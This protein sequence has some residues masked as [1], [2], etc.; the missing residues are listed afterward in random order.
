MSRYH[1]IFFRRIESEE[2][3]IYDTLGQTIFGSKRRQR[4][5]FFLYERPQAKISYIKRWYVAVTHAKF[6]ASFL[7]SRRLRKRTGGLSMIRSNCH[8]SGMHMLD[9]VFEKG[10]QS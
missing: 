9:H 3:E 5:V 7:I 10:G 8:F 1:S 2:N 6:W 4:I